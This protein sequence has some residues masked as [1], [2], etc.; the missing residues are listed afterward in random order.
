MAQARTPELV[1]VDFIMPRMNGLQFMRSFRAVENQKEIPVVLVSVKADSMGENFMRAT[2]AVDALTKPFSSDSLLTVVQH[3]LRTPRAG[4]DPRAD[5]AQ[6]FLTDDRFEPERVEDSTVESNAALAR[7]REKLAE[8]ISANLGALDEEEDLPL[9][10]MLQKA[11][12]DDML[13]SLV[14]DYRTVDPTAGVATFAGSSEAVSVGEVMQL[15]LHGLSEGTLEIQGAGMRA[16]I[17]FTNGR[18]TLAQLK[19]GPDEFLLGRYLLK[20]ELITRDELRRLLAAKDPKQPLGEKLV[21]SGYI[22][23]EDLVQALTLQS[24]EVLY[25]VL[26]WQTSRYR[27]V[28]GKLPEE[29]GSVDLSISVGELLMEG[30]RRVD[31]WRVIEK[32]LPDFNAV[33]AKT[34]AGIEALPPEA[35]LSAAEARVLDFVNGTN[36]IREVIRQT[37]LG[38]FDAC[39]ILH[40]FI[41]MRVIKKVDD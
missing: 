28:P 2:G 38:S 10:R 29:A 7:I 27:F 32:H 9:E 41:M 20:E 23:R 37:R 34:P 18:V 31:E 15:L 39:K 11:L 35:T 24:T 6:P 1:L 14:E 13:A 3:A 16:M 8:G 17:Y 40:Q 22:S 26:R 36:T 5:R 4:A 21:R 33:L 25:E 30:L 19:G 12:S